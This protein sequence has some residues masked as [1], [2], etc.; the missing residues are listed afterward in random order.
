MHRPGTRIEALRRLLEAEETRQSRID[1]KRMRMLASISADDL[2]TVAKILDECAREA[3]CKREIRESRARSEQVCFVRQTAMYLARELTNLS[4]N[5]IGAY[6]ARHHSTVIH[7]WRETDARGNS[8]P[9]F[10][11][12]LFRIAKAIHQSAQE[13][14]A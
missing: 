12:T 8:N 1:G 2:A 10:K 13:A 3:R 6:F 7:A 14:A 11:Q 4:W 9:V 5:Q